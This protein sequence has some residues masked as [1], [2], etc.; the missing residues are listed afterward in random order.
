MKEW[1]ALANWEQKIGAQDPIRN[2]F[3]FL[4]L[5]KD[6]QNTFDWPPNCFPSVL[7][8]LQASH[9][10]WNNEFAHK[11]KQ[12]MCVCVFFW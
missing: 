9:L 2:L 7:F 5:F 3:Y 11:T 10:P 4:D 8:F 12:I 6:F 1:N